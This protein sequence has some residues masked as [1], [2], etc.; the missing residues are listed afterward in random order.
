VPRFLD[1]PDLPLP[2][3]FPT[4]G[5]DK[6]LMTGFGMALAKRVGQLFEGWRLDAVGDA[7][8]AK[9]YRLTC[10]GPPTPLP[11]WVTDPSTGDDAGG[12]HDAD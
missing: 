6:A 11:A 8:N 2:L 10:P 5:T 3:G 4:G 7:H 12:T 1:A 9:V